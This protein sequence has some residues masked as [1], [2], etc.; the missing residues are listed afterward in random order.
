MAITKPYE[1]GLMTIP[2]SDQL[3]VLS[4]HVPNHQADE[5]IIQLIMAH[6]LAILGFLHEKYSDPRNQS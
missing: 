1:H 5:Y 3:V 4:I 6:H 2:K